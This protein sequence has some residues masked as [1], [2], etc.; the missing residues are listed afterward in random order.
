MAG[1]AMSVPVVGTILLAATRFIDYPMLVTI[2][3][4]VLQ[5]L[6]CI[7][8]L[9]AS[10]KPTIPLKPPKKDLPGLIKALERMLFG[11]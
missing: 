8:L 11:A 5:G 9:R 3:G 2:V 6:W 4:T 10:R 7:Q 1:N